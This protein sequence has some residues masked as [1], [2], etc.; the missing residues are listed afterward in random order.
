[1]A[2]ADAAHS[3]LTGAEV[4]VLA[5][6]GFVVSVGYSAL[7]PA[8]PG[9]LGSFDPSLA[10]ST[11]AKQVGELSG[12]YMLGVFVGALAAGYLSDWVGRRP[13]L[14]AGLTMFLVTQV[15]TVHIESLM[16]LY[17][18]RFLAGLSGAAVLAVSAA[19]TADG[20]PLASV[21]R[22]LAYLGA[23]S[24]LGFLIGPTIVSLPQ[25]VGADVRWGVSGP[26]ALLA[27]AMHATLGLGILVVIALFWIRP[28][29][30]Q[31][32][33]ITSRSSKA[34]AAGRLP[35][36]ALLTLNFATLLGLGGFEVALTLYG[37]QRLQLDTLRISLMFA[38]CSMVMLLVNGVLFLTPLWRFVSVRTVLM[39][40][41]GAMVG[42]FVLL[43]RSTSYESVLG[44]VPLI[45]A[46]SGMAMPTLAY[47]VASRAGRLGA[48]MGQ[49][50]AAGSLGQALGSFAG[51]WLFA[52]LAAGSFLI[53]AL[54][55]ALALLLLAWIGIRGLPTMPESGEQGRSF[56]AKFTLR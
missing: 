9:W 5:V 36:F 46:G 20:S 6:A 34:S 53:G 32:P 33:S 2:S 55:M 51:G 50:T 1:M 24:L 19:F 45:A 31:A 22:R 27:F 49:L 28:V 11:I 56:K 12:I 26:V 42:G 7:I 10:A 30:S 3:G 47:S 48:A 41:M 15:A 54:F 17:V 29:A 16:S 14:L 40:S 35:L 52:V 37:S 25:L 8:L 39:L 38:E 23:A 18:L 44:A 4:S 13:V 21:P 43:Y